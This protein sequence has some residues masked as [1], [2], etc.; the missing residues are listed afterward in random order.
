MNQCRE[1]GTIIDECPRQFNP[2][3]KHGLTSPDETLFV[4]FQMHGQTSFFL[5]RQPSNKELD[6]YQRHYLTSEKEWDLMPDQFVEAEMSVP[7]FIGATSSHDRRSLIQPEEMVK[8]WGTSLEASRIT[9]KEATNQCTVHNVRGPLGIR[10]KTSQ[11]QLNHKQLGTKFYSDTFFPRVTCLRGNTCAQLL[12]SSDGYAKV[13][14]MELKSEAGSKLNELC[15]NV[16][17]PSRLFTDN[18]GEETG[19]EW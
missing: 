10:Y 18:D 7:R 2:A 6:E 17:I 1:G 15:S 11:Q 5:I 14:P 3:F 9:F 19:G 13:Y 8:R 4:P 16:G 12:C